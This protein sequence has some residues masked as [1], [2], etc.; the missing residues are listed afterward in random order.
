[1]D[2]F[3]GMQMAPPRTGAGY[4]E[5]SATDVVIPAVRKE[6]GVQTGRFAHGTTRFFWGSEKKK[7]L[8]LLT[9][10]PSTGKGG[11]CNIQSGFLLT[12]RPN[13]YMNRQITA[14]SGVLIHSSPHPHYYLHLH[15]PE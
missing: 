8:F 5:V 2:G 15:L 14:M 12:P 4:K 3:S 9:L 7:G 13:L 1:M 6:V 10:L 11:V